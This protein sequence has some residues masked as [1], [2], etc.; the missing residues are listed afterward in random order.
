MKRIFI[1]VKVT[2][3]AELLKAAANLR[4]LLASESIKWT[5]MA[6]THLT[7]AFLGDTEE[8]RIKLVAGMLGDRCAGFREFS[9]NIKGTGVFKSYRDPRVIWAG[10]TPAERLSALEVEINSGL[11]ENGFMIPDR[12]FRPHLTLGRIRSVKNNDY[13]REVVERYEDTVFQTVTAN[14]VILFESILK[15]TG[16]IYK[17]LGRF[18]LKQD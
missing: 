15:Q 9:F 6:N 8:D 4:A 18:G 5:D 1:A 10:I 2:P 16:P 13:L 7:L 3:E 14:E 11:A 17:P 12:P